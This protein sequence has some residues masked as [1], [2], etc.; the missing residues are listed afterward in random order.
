MNQITLNLFKISKKNREKIMVDL[1]SSGVVFRERYNM[2]VSIEQ[3][4]NNQPEYLL[5]YF[6]KRLIYY[7]IISKKL[8]KSF[9]KI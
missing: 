2:P 6:R 7:R 3:I 5:S 1:A 8:K 4:E 9:K